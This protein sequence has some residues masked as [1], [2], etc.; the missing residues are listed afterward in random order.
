MGCCVDVYRLHSAELD[1][2]ENEELRYRRLVELNVHEQIAMLLYEARGL[3]MDEYAGDWTFTGDHG[4]TRGHVPGTSSGCGL[5]TSIAKGAT[6]CAAVDLRMGC[7]CNLLTSAR[8]RRR[9][10]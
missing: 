6:H 7:D 9:T 3:G 8:F 10:G 1:S 2:I 5:S 4:G